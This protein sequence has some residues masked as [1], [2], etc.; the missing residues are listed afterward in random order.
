MKTKP[1]VIL[2]VIM[3]M[4]GSPGCATVLTI[5]FPPLHETKHGEIKTADVVAHN[6]TLSES[7]TDLI[8]EKQPL[9]AQKVQVIHVKRKQ[10]HGVVPAM[11]EIPFF[12]FGIF[13]LVMAGC[14]TLATKEEIPGEF[15]DIPDMVIC[16]PVQPAP[17]EELV[18]QFTDSLATVRIRTNEYG[19]LPLCSVRE[20]CAGRSRFNVFI[21][22]KDGVSYVK[23]FDGKF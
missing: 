18:L 7:K 21:V 9:C 22:E 15:V 23:T 14:F 5:A 11:V 19:R 8:L 1:L 12:G 17:D 2:S 6:Y 3:A 20:V 4:I 13:D 10:L 16:G